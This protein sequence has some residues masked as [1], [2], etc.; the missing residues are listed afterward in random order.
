MPTT[1]KV[2]SQLQCKACNKSM[3]AKNLKYSHAAYCITRVHEVDKPKAIP[4][5]KKIS[6]N[7]KKIL[8]V[9]GVTQ[10]VESDDD[11]MQDFLNDCI[12]PSDNTEINPMTKLTHQITKAQEDYKANNKELEPPMHKVE[13]SHKT[14][15][16][17][18]P[19][20]EVIMKSAR[21]KTKEKYHK[22]K[23]KAF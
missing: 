4:V 1:V 9:K 2:I 5:P 14:E 12:K 23:S 11:D 6:P 3:S 15:N 10:D 8:P 18:Q 17:I 7:L 21:G 19:T 22:L 13:D 20:Y 16:I